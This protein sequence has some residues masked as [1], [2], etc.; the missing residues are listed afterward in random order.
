MCLTGIV[1]REGQLLFRPVRVEDDHTNHPAGQ[2]RSGF[3]AVGQAGADGFLLH[4][5]AVHN[6]IDGMLDVL[7]QLDFFR[8]I[9]HASVH[10]DADIAALGRVLEDLLVHT[11][12]RTDHRREDH[13][14]LAVLQLHQLRDNLVDR[15]L[16]DDLAA[17]RAVGNADAR[18][19]QTQIVVNF[20][21]G[22]DGRARVLR[23]GFLIDGNRR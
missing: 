8:Q 5:E 13:K 16:L 20:R 14:A 22:T 21:N 12:L 15:L 18:I 7:I 4:H 23:G 9:V 11:L 2:R 6:D 1:L 17:D 3:D 10:T 19:E